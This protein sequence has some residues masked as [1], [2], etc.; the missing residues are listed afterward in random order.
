MLASSRHTHHYSNVTLNDQLEQITHSKLEMGKNHHCSGFVWVLGLQR[1][2]SGSFHFSC[3]WVLVLFGYLK[4]E[5]SSSVRFSVRFRFYSHLYFKIRQNA[6]LVG[7][8][9]SGRFVKQQQWEG[10]WW[11]KGKLVI[12]CC[13][14]CGRGSPLSASRVRG[15]TAVK[16]WVFIMQNP[17]I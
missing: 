3:I 7:A 13:G 12:A 9:P 16:F 14:G 5:G 15:Y 8:S 4:I 1:F 11:A 6:F 2:C 17:A 10:R